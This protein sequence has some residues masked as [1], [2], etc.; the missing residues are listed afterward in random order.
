MKSA[1]SIHDASGLA[2]PAGLGPAQ[3]PLLTDCCRQGVRDPPAR[4][5]I[6]VILRGTAKHSQT[7]D[8][9]LEA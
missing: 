6:N 2:E 5:D 4:V 8:D 7:E 3:L 9:I 1:R